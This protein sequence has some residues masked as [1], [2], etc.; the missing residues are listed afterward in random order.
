MNYV[1]FFGQAHCCNEDRGLSLNIFWTKNTFY[2]FVW[3]S[4]IAQYVKLI[5]VIFEN[6]SVL[7]YFDIIETFYSYINIPFY[8]YIN[9]LIEKL[10]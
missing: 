5:H 2:V 3:F 1:E 7:L 8:P 10:T 9:I 6:K 4:R